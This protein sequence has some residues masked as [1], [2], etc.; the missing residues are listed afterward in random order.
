MLFCF[1]LGFLFVCFLSY[2]V[3]SFVVQ[4]MF[5][6]LACINRIHFLSLLCQCVVS[7][8]APPAPYLWRVVGFRFFSALFNGV[9]CGFVV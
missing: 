6:F 4:D 7:A 8:L 1:A 2:I 3:P 5:L 9:I